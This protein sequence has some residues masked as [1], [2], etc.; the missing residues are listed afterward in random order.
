MRWRSRQRDAL[1]TL[2]PPRARIVSVAYQ[3]ACSLFDVERISPTGDDN[4]NNNN[5]DDYDD[6]DD[7]DYDDD[8]YDDDYDDDSNAALV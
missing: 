6:D 3:S 7:D 1:Y 8:D 5:D 4:N 2:H